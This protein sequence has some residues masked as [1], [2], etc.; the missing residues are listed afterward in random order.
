MV[1][2]KVPILLIQHHCC[3]VLKI[4]RIELDLSLFYYL[5][6][7]SF[8]NHRHPVNAWYP[9]LHYF[10]Y[11]WWWH[12]KV[13][14]H[15]LLRDL[16]LIIYH[17]WFHQSRSKESYIILI[18]LSYFYKHSLPISIKEQSKSAL[19]NLNMVMQ[20]YILALS[21]SFDINWD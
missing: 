14:F 6:N 9:N 4:K 19:K 7:Q 20:L 1:I 12:L 2:R 16:S 17:E 15:I 11:Q 13:T 10:L 8:G 21:L 5:E 3:Y 18:N